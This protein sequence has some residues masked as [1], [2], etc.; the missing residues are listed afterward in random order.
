MLFFYNK[1]VK[2]KFHSNFTTIFEFILFIL[3][4]NNINILN[5]NNIILKIKNLSRFLYIVLL[6]QLKIRLNIIKKIIKNK[7]KIIYILNS[8]YIFYT[9]IHFISHLKGAGS[10]ARTHDP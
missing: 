4:T 1:Y 10:G 6:S 2:I 7:S 9:F 3:Y 5:K 8:L